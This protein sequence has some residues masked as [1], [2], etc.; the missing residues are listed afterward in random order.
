MAEQK[1]TTSFIPK[2]P[3]QTVGVGGRLGRS[4]TNIF[5]L[6][7][8][9]IF[10]ATIIVT[11]GVFVYKIKLQ[12]DIEKQN[13][14]L[15]ETVK[16]LDNE[17]KFVDEATKLNERMIGV[18]KLL[19]SHMSPSQIFFLLE[20]KTLETVK[21]DKL[22]FK[23]DE[24]NNLILSGTGVASNFESIIQQSDEYGKNS[25][26]RDVIFSNLQN[27]EGSLVSFSFE[28]NIDRNFILY[29]NSLSDEKRALF[30]NPNIQGSDDGGVGTTTGNGPVQQP[31]INNIQ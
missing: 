25:Y 24:K 10:L 3:I 1:F 12:N 6:I 26:L 23:R 29:V 13:V 15:Y 5:S 17:L 31:L 18:Q 19:D 8:L 4:S 27:K 2:K 28:S 20:S 21:F 14:N 7:A 11:A 9:L 22:D 30:L 16:K